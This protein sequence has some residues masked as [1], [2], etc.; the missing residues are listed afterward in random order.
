VKIEPVTLYTRAGC[1]LCDDAKE[2][3]TRLGVT[4]T[5]VDVDA[6]AALLTRYGTRVPV[7]EREGR[8]LAE[9]NIGEARAPL[10]RLLRS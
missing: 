4:W 5:E 3:L 2:A 7:I 10:A 1:H 8:V 9:G 6:D